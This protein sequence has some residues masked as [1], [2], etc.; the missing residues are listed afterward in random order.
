MRYTE[1]ATAQPFE[2]APRIT[3]PRIFGA[4]PKK[5]LLMRI[6]VLGKRTVS[7]SASGLPEGVRLD[8]NVISG[9]ASRSGDYKIKLVCENEL[10][11]DETV[12]TLK[13]N[14]DAVQLTPLMGFTSWNAFGHYVTQEKIEHTAERMAELGL[15]EYGYCYVNTDSGWQGEYGG[16]YDAIMPNASFPDMKGMCDKIHSLGFHAGIYA[17]PRFKD[18]FVPSPSRSWRYSVFP[19]TVLIMFCPALGTYCLSFSSIQAF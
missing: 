4:S 6:G 2:G 14:K 1:L 16:K 5:P 3:A 8:G 13:I 18:S 10:G 19:R 7:Y 17:N 11:R 15:G 12:V 9:I